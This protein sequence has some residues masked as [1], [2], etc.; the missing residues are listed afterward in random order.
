M[1]GFDFDFTKQQLAEIIKGNLNNNLQK[2][3]KET[4]ILIIGIML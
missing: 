3:S 1:S 2:L 4:P